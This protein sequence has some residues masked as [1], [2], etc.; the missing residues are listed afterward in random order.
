MPPHSAGRVSYPRLT[1]TGLLLLLLL[2]AGAGWAVTVGRMDGMDAGPGTDLGGLDW[3][4][5]GWA[6]MMAAMMLPSLFPAALLYARIRSGDSDRDRTSSFGATGLFVAAL[7]GPLGDGW[8]ARLRRD[9]GRS[10]A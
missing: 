4:I 1:E 6:V 7:P 2:L 9:R 8:G 10:L 5:V 3:F